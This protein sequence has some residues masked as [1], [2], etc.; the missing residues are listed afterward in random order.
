MQMIEMVR[1][2]KINQKHF[3]ENQKRY[4]KKNRYFNKIMK[5]NY[6]H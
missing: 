4:N 5:K 3:K 6:K 2:N 1:L